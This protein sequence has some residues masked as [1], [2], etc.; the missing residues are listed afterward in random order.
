MKHAFYLTFAV[1]AGLSIFLAGCGS[2]SKPT[3]MVAATSVPHAE[4]LELIQPDLRAQKID[5]EIFIIDD[6]NTPNRALADG[7]VDANY[8]QHLP[9]LEAQKA[10][11]GYALEPLAAVHLEPMALYS[12]K[13]ASIKGIKERGTIALPSDP[14]NQA[15]ALALCEQAG[16]ITLKP[17]GTK[18]T[19]LDILDNPLHLAFVE[20]DSPLLA[21]SLDDVDAAAISTNFALLGG[22]A[23]QKDALAVEKGQSRYA[24]ILVIREG[25]K[26]NAALQA[27]KAALT[28]EKVRQYMDHHY[29][30][31]VIPSF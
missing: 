23:P 25:E 3:L 13:T 12:K 2:T 30:G 16:L 27:L 14:S 15:R 17:N 28:S 31:A 10:D 1:I 9:F 8:F 21:R 24:N 7:E 6:F 26:D 29:Q 22:L 19:P 18:T 5:L 4:I 20:M 11:F